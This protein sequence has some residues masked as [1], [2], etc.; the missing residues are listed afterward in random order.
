MLTD[1]W[2][3]RRC[4]A[5]SQQSHRTVTAR[6]TFIN[7]HGCGSAAC[8]VGKQNIQIQCAAVGETLTHHMAVG[9]QNNLRV[10]IH[11]CKHAACFDC[12]DKVRIVQRQTTRN[13]HA[14]A[15]G[16]RRTP[17][18]TVVI[19]IGGKCD[20]VTCF[21]RFLTS[22]FIAGTAGFCFGGV[23]RKCGSVHHFTQRHRLIAVCSVAKRRTIHDELTAGGRMV[24]LTNPAALFHQRVQ[25]CV[26]I[27]S[28]EGICQQL[29]AAVV[30]PADQFIRVQNIHVA[31]I[32][33]HAPLHAVNR[34]EIC[35]TGIEAAGQIQTR[36]IQI[37][38]CGRTGGCIGG[39]RTVVHMVMFGC[40]QEIQTA[41][42]CVLICISRTIS[43]GL[44]I[45]RAGTTAQR[46][47]AVTVIGLAV[48][49][50]VVH[51]VRQRTGG[52]NGRTCYQTIISATGCSLFAGARWQT[53]ECRHGWRSDF[54]DLHWPALYFSVFTQGIQCFF[55]ELIQRYT[56][57]HRHAGG[58]HSHC[59][60]AYL[61]IAIGQHFAGLGFTTPE[62]FLADR[63]TTDFF[64]TVPAVGNAA[65]RCQQFHAPCHGTGGFQMLIFELNREITGI[66]TG[67]QIRIAFERHMQCR[68]KFM[69]IFNTGVRNTGCAEQ[70]CQADAGRNAAQTWQF[71]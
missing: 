51:G 23:G 69:V 9:S 5:G 50:T 32:A 18:G 37:F 55:C 40:Q 7:F 29:V 66:R 4:R 3:D 19:L 54:T 62:N 44:R 70:T 30:F 27:F 39:I 60:Q 45:L 36:L 48:Q 28:D 49:V 8:A 41:V 2:G 22:T 25:R 38:R 71:E 35:V 68:F 16:I 31:A 58:I 57:H 64:D 15:V 59:G 24:K 26:I 63:L 65:L 67:A 33:D 14:G 46:T 1:G 13:Q 47:T 34:E 6:H 42:H 20:V 10:F 11:G 53:G 61:I 56:G 52:S 17:V 12:I 21:Q 43:S